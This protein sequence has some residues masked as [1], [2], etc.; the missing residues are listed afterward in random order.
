MI[1]WINKC[2]WRNFE[3]EFLISTGEDRIYS[4]FQQDL[5]NIGIKMEFDQMDAN[6]AFAKTMK[7][8]FEVTSQG[9]T[10]GFFPKY[11]RNDAQ[12]IC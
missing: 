2:I 10:A 7:K 12:Q 5:A 9:W 3:F 4:S 1:Q 8:Q 6:G 11:G